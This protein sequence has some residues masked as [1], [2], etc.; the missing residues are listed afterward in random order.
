MSWNAWLR[1][2]GNRSN[3]YQSYNTPSGS[4][5][6]GIRKTSS[7]LKLTSPLKQRK[8]SEAFPGDQAQD[9]LAQA[10]SERGYLGNLWVDKLRT[11]VKSRTGVRLRTKSNFSWISKYSRVLHLSSSRQKTPKTIFAKAVGCINTIDRLL[12]KRKLGD[13]HM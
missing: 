10:F 12:G 4:K 8:R 13:L 2:A 1:Y 6:V 5:E 7:P 11:G 3:P 9:I